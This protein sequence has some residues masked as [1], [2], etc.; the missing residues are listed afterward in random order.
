MADI[1]PSAQREP[2]A[3]TGYRPG[4]DEK[5]MVMQD[6]TPEEQEAYERS[7][8]LDSFGQALAKTRSDAIAYR[9]QSGIEQIWDEDNDFFEG[10]DDMN[11]GDERSIR[12]D[13]PP[14]AGASTANRGSV[15]RGQSRVFPN[16]TG[17][18]VEAAAAH[19]SDILLPTEDKPPWSFEPTPIPEL[20][21]QAEQYAEE[22]PEAAEA[23]SK[24]GFL[25]RVKDSVTAEGRDESEA[26]DEAMVD[27]SPSMD[28]E[29]A[30]E[31]MEM[32][33]AIAEATQ[34]RVWDWQVEAQ[35]NAHVRVVLEDAARVGTGVIKGPVPKEQMN[36]GW[37]A[38]ADTQDMDETGAPIQSEGEIILTKDTSP[39][40][41]RVDCWNLFPAAG[42]GD[43]IQNGDHIWE[44]DYLT[45]RQLRKL[46]DDDSYITAQIHEC[47]REGPTRAVAEIP[48]T[49]SLTTTSE[50]KDKYEVWY[51]YCMA[52][53]KDLD[54]AGV[55]TEDIEDPHID[56]LVVLVNNRVIRASLPTIDHGGFP[57]DVFCWRKRSNF[58]AGIGVARQVRTAQKIVVGATRAMMN[59]AGLAGGPMLV[60]KQG[61]VRPA[62][63]VAGLAPR[64]VFYI[65]KDDQTIADATKA[66]GVIKVD[67]MVAEMMQIIQYGLQIGENNSGFPLLMQGQMGNAPDLVGVVNVLDKNTN[68]IKRRLSRNYSDGVMVPHLRRY[69]IYHLMYGPDNEKGDLQVNVKGYAALVERDIQNQ[70]LGQMYS[71][72]TDPRF[73]LDPKKWAE[74]YLKSRHLTTSDLAVDEEEWGKMLEQFQQW[75]ESQQG[76]DPRVQVAQINAKSRLDAAHISG[77]FAGAMKLSD[78]QAKAVEKQKDREM[79]LVLEAAGKEMEQM[80]LQGATA[81]SLRKAKTTLATKVMDIQATW[82]LAMQGAPADQMPKPP[83]EPPGRAPDGQSF[84]K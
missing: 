43:D 22:N 24:K 55:D 35:F 70:E 29:Q 74:E 13:K 1:S 6:M 54:A 26:R 9:Q 61:V 80:V 77:Q 17:P 60:F 73:G 8:R 72:V 44:R 67:I 53:R 63:G 39:I 41:K 34:T 84:Q 5:A 30:F 27:Q 33:K 28:P 18:F 15:A 3:N 48:E 12:N 19:I 76:G 23:S 2:E 51:G 16:I 66:I 38:G 52:E 79:Q 40:S 56:C 42:C 7:R 58:W 81:D 45:T 4:Q 59:N 64:K 10:V 82:K 32:A 83:V 21:E 57:Y 46:K 11:R 14:Q 20:I 71:I 36:I 49:R 37:R 62:D 47:L 68:A 65:A 31:Q 25:A 50:M 75:Q 69:Y 78:N